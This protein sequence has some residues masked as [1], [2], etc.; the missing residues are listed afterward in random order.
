MQ[1]GKAIVTIFSLLMTQIWA[2]V[3]ASNFLVITVSIDAG[4]RAVR[5]VAR[6]SVGEGDVFLL[7]SFHTFCGS[8][9]ASSFNGYRRS[10]AGIKWSRR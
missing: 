5:Y 7:P 1:C 2:L 10:F 4:L 3:I 9:A 6:I 8:H